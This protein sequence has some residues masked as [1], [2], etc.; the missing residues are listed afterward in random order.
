MQRTPTAA[1]A[2]RRAALVLLL[3]LCASLAAGSAV[4]RAALGPTLYSSRT[5]FWT[6][7]LAALAAVIVSPR[8]L[9]HWEGTGALGGVLS[10]ATLGT[11]TGAGLGLFA[12][13][14]LA[15]ENQDLLAGMGPVSLSWLAVL[16]SSLTGLIAGACIGFPLGAFCMGI[17]RLIL[18][19][20]DVTGEPRHEKETRR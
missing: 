13:L 1:S 15:G 20:P 16:S 12:A 5:L 6:M 4:S 14:H 17:A 9:R 7:A 10:G 19:A 8:C 2:A 3:S 11:L 18:D